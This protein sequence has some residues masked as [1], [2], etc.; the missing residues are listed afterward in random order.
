ML[1]AY[2]AEIFITP[3]FFAKV[4]SGLSASAAV[5]KSENK[6]NK[7]FFFIFSSLLLLNNFFSQ[8]QI[9]QKLLLRNIVNILR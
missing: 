7:I 1:F 8:F 3:S 4:T 2:C 6:E 9:F 5:S